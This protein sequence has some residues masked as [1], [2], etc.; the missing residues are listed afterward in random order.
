MT[1]N[2]RKNPN[3]VR[4]IGGQW[5]SRVLQFPETPGLR[6]TGDRVRETLFNWLQFQITGARCLDLFAGS[7]VLGFEA[8]SRGATRVTSLET[9]SKAAAAIRAN[10]HLL[11]T[12]KLDLVQ[13]PALDWL[14]HATNPTQHDI[15]FLD[16]PFAAGLHEHCCALL[17][18]RGWLASGAL[19]YIEASQA[20]SSFK[21]PATWTLQREKRAGEVYYSLFRASQHQ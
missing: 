3:R 2:S 7:G 11:G 6:P 13:T 9:D 1:V 20:P 12:D 17:E 5:R 19:V 21:L 16:P 8:I 14:Q 18:E 4:I 10:C 15:V